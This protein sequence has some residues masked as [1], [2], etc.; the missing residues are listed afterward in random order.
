MSKIYIAGPITDMPNNNH[1]EFALAEQ[2]LKGK[3]HRVVNPHSIFDSIDTTG[4]DH[5]EYMKHC[6][7]E[8]AHCD[9]VVTL[10]GWETSKGAKQEVDIARIMGKPVKHIIKY[11]NESEK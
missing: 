1:S 10:Q 11:F 8:L 4:F 6:V 7:S 3:G 5:S 9:E 2:Y